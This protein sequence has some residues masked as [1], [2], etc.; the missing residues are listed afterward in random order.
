MYHDFI[1]KLD[2]KVLGVTATPYRLTTDVFGGSILKFLTRTRPR[3]FEHVIFHVQNRQ[4][5]DEGYLAPLRY[6]PVGGFDR[7][8]LQLNSTGADYT[9]ESVRTYYGSTGFPDVVAKAVR[10]LQTIRKG[11]LVF[12][13]FVEESEYLVKN[14]PGSAIVTGETPKKEREAIIKAFRAGEIRVVANCAV[15][16]I[17]FDYPELDTVILACPT[18]SLARYYQ[19]IGRAIRPCSGK[20]SALVVDLCGNIDQFGKIEDLCKRRSKSVTGAGG[21]L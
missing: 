10:Q 11:V 6:I 13:R 7:S 20:T 17:G 8:R 16:G 15:L 5:F 18:M 1:G 12:T 14:I 3:I 4:L 2:A 21:K 9:D 19:W